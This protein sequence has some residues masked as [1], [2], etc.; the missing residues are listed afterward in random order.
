MKTRLLNP[1]FFINLLTMASAKGFD[2]GESSHSFLCSYFDWF[3]N[4]EKAIILRVMTFGNYASKDNGFL[5]NEKSN[6]FQ[7]KVNNFITS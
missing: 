6:F 2:P 1:I 3:K 7:Q 5:K 4:V